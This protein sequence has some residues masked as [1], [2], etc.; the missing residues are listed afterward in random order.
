MS[1]PR[2]VHEVLE[3]E[4]VSMYGPLDRL[5]AAYTS[6][7]IVDVA[8]AASILRDCGVVLQEPTR[9]VLAEQLNGFVVSLQPDALA[10]SPALT[11]VGRSLLAQYTELSAIARK[12]GRLDELN[13]RIVDDAFTG[14]VKSQRDLR[15]ANVYA[16]LHARAGDGDK[17]RTALCISGGGIRS[18]TF[19]LG[20]MQ[21]LASAKVLDKFD[22]LSTVSGGGYIGSWLSS[23]ARRHPHGIS[24]VQEDLAACDSAASGARHVDDPPGRITRPEERVEKIEPEPQPVR[25]LREYSN[26]LSPRLGLLSGD[27]WTMAALYFRNLLLNLL[28]LV[29]VFAAVLAIPRAYAWLTVK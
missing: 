24:G 8:W 28:V 6:D 29:P 22:Y 5:S 14:A 26:Y 2:E 16:A 21:G 10:E 3:D 20:V 23:W 11:S 15:L 1:L 13:R 9:A 27:T 19:A 25:R 12:E 17:A 4:Y 18:A 7:Q